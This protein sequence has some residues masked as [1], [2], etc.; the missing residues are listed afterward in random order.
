M[1]FYADRIFFPFRS[2]PWQG[3]SSCPPTS[4]PKSTIRSMLHLRHLTCQVTRTWSFLKPVLEL[5]WTRKTF[6]TPLRT[7]TCSIVKIKRMIISWPQT[8]T[9]WGWRFLTI[10]SFLQFFYSFI[11]INTKRYTDGTCSK[12]K[13]QGKL[14]YGHSRFYLPSGQNRI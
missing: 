11:Y 12:E 3:N 6:R 14:T 13:K 8:H 5:P 10:F 2:N 1:S 4:S 9:G 7:K